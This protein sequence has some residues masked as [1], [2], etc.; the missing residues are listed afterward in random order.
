MNTDKKEL[1][2]A[3]THLGGAVFGIIG[4]FFLLSH[5]KNSNNTMTAVAYL[6]FGLSMIL[7]Y[8]ASTIYHF[9]DKSKA[10]A[11]L[12]MRKLDHIMIFVLI[13]GTYTP[14]CLLVLDKTTGY[15]LLTLVW[16][17]TIIGALIKLF[18]IKAPNWVSSV[19]YITM[20]WLAVLVLS[21][22]VNNMLP[23]GVIWL[24][25]GGISYTVGGVIYGIKRPNINKTYFGFHELFHLFVL[26]GT[27][28]HFVM[29]YF[30]VG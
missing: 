14:I 28:C 12:I 26:A 8:S 27:F 24:I 7:L 30:Y 1:T 21:P 16:T 22:L 23:R 19:L 25:T 6:I 13:A 10:K 9:I 29:I 11:K 17:I 15:R 4:T 20:G 5:A 18:W 3:L 2:S